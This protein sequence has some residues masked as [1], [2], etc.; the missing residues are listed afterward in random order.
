MIGNDDDGALVS[1]VLDPEIRIIPIII[2]DLD[3]L[4]ISDTS[5]CGTYIFDI[6]KRSPQGLVYANAVLFARQNLIQAIAKHNY[7]VLLEERRVIAVY[8]LMRSRLI[9]LLLAAGH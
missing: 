7:N 9:T 2:P 5:T 6:G 1:V 8:I 4:R 3:I